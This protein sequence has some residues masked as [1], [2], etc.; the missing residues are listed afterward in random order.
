MKHFHNVVRILSGLL[1]VVV[2]ASKFGILPS[3][4]T[5]EHMF[6]PE[7]WAFIS[8]I[9]A[10]GY[11]FPAVGVVALVCGV[12]FL[13]NRYVALAAVVLM[14]ITVSFALF[15]VFLGFPIDSVFSF[16]FV[17]EGV[18]FVPLVLNLTILYN[19]RSKYHALTTG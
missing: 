8:A 5:R 7:G 11:L 10:T 9:N 1:F 12:A 17:R 2:A 3:G 6:T 18:S 13:T 16:H 14:P 19:M 15:H 4:V